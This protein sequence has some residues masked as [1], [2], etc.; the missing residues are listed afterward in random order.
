MKKIYN[1]IFALALALALTIS[2]ASLSGEY[3]DGDY[4]FPEDIFVFDDDDGAEDVFANDDE[5]IIEDI[6]A[7]DDGGFANIPSDMVVVED[8]IEALALDF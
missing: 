2:A 7:D 6:D 8:P 1:M 4:S 3:G 5:D